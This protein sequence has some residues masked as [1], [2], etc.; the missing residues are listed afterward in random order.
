MKLRKDIIDFIKTLPSNVTLVVASKY[1][2][3]SEMEKLYQLGVTNFGEN[4]AD[5][6][7]AKFEKLSNLNIN[8]HFIGHLQRNKA[9]D[10][11]DK[12][13]YLHSL[14]S[15]KLAKIIEDNRK[16]PL[17]TF[18]EV[19]INHEENKSGVPY[20]Q[21][22]DFVKDILNYNKIEL[23]GLMMMAKHD[24]NE[25]TLHQEFKKLKQI[26]RHLEEKFSIT[27]PYLSMGMSRDY[28]IAIEEG[29]THI[30]LGKILFTD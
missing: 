5:S 21:I 13:S 7:L 26:K 18:I 22:D 11:I 17:K 20:E 23:I 28:L 25:I 29:A 24:D 8:W 19:D 6:F 16:K 30:R 27:L 4:R 12:I 15:L 10:I 9:L 1:I 2:D 3:T 14:D